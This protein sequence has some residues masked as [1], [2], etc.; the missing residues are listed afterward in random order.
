[1]PSL[2][3]LPKNDGCE[4]YEYPSLAGYGS[5]TRA[6]EGIDNDAV[7]RQ[8]KLRMMLSEADHQRSDADRAARS[9]R[10]SAWKSWSPIWTVTRTGQW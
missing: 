7:E 6:S 2:I 8:S 10:A 3:K 4:L 9:S 1:M 5:G